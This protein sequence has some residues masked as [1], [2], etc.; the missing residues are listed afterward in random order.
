ML[1][2]ICFL[3]FWRITNKKGKKGKI[4]AKLNKKYFFDF[5]E[6]KLCLQTKKGTKRLQSCKVSLINQKVN[7][8]Y[9]VSGYFFAF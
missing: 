6:V 3:H 2:E 1:V 9:S 5:S 7:Q 4:E 8:I